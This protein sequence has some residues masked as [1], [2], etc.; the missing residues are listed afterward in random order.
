MAVQFAA[1]K[2]NSIRKGSGESRRQFINININTMKKTFLLCVVAC[3]T[4]ICFAQKSNNRL[5]NKQ[6]NYESF[7]FYKG[8]DVSYGV[9]STVSVMGGVR[10]SPYF[11]LG[12]GAG[13]N[14]YFYAEET[15]GLPLFA[16][17][18]SNIKPN[19]IVSPYFTLR[20]G[21]SI[22]LWHTDM[23]GFY[24]EPA[25]GVSV[26]VADMTRIHFALGIVSLDSAYH[27]SIKTGVSF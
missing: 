16:F 13:L 7:N 15:V 25:G 27:L 8:F 4:T 17:V 9:V 14:S 21:Y 5:Y 26:L 24:Y 12:V 22:P 18:S 23:D 11:D 20:A 19:R 1:V 3:L 2:N 10:L 6:F